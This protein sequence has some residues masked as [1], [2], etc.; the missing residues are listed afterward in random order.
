[1]LVQGFQNVLKY[2]A[3]YGKVGSC[4]NQG[5]ARPLKLGGSRV[6][7]S[8]QPSSRLALTTLLVLTSCIT[9]D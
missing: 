8:V 1:M 7:G 9:I 2:A 6:A 3:D 4:D 5:A